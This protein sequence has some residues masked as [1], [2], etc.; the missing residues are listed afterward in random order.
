M[1]G[2]GEVMEEDVEATRGKLE[3][4]DSLTF[5]RRE[6]GL[7]K[8]SGKAVAEMNR[9]VQN[10]QDA[11]EAGGVLLGRHILGG[12]DIV[13]DLVTVP[14]IEDRRSRYRFS[15]AREQ[16]QAVIDSVWQKSEKTCTYL[17]EWHTHP[18]RSPVPSGVDRRDWRRRLREDQ[19][20]G[21]GLFFVIVG[22]EEIAV[23][24]GFEQD[25]SCKRL[26]LRSETNGVPS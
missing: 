6:K 22:T 4:A 21:A 25:R 23:W 16:H 18:E 13:A 3:I 14:R 20:Y 5:L 12:Q 26:Q 2:R 7:L 17:G 15:R 11:Q 1:R 9:Y 10:E 24:E 19:F 8:L